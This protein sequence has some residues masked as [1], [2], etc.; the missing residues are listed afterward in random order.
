VASL[1]T[2]RYWS[3]GSVALSG[4]QSSPVPGASKYRLMGEL[5][6]HGRLLDRGEAAAKAT[7]QSADIRVPAPGGNTLYGLRS[8]VLWPNVPVGELPAPTT[9]RIA[10]A[11]IEVADFGAGQTAA[12]HDLGARAP[13]LIGDMV[14]DRRD[15]DTLSVS[16]ALGSMPGA[17]GGTLTLRWVQDAIPKT[18]W[19]WSVV[20]PPGT[21]AVTLPRLPERL[22]A[23]RP[24]ATLGTAKVRVDVAFHAS[25]YISGYADYRSRWRDALGALVNANGSITSTRLRTVD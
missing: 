19:T 14:M 22:A 3:A 20:V 11:E 13:G 2:W 4:T 12:T 25:T 6:N 17:D 16:W 9:P 1:T 8:V 15:P 21:T 7:P 10:R 18:E 23:W 24:S 5:W